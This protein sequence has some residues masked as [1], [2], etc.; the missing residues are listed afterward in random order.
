MD[1]QRVPAILLMEEHLIVGEVETRG[2]RMLDVLNETMADWLNVHDAH[3][4]RRWAKAQAVATAGDLLIRK[5]DVKIAVLGGGKHEAPEKRRFARVE[6]KQFS[7]LALVGSYEVKGSLH[8]KAKREPILLLTELGSFIPLT[9]ATISHAAPNDD[10]LEADVAIINKSAIGAFHIG[11][12]LPSPPPDHPLTFS[13]DL[14]EQ[15][16]PR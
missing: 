6:K 12:A 10:K 5:A 14:G 13:A 16:L 8:L 7:A 9:E 1:A 3:I 11:D 4:S 2:H 15:T